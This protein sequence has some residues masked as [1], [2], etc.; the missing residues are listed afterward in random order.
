[1]SIESVL[2]SADTSRVQAG[3]RSWYE[4][5]V[6]FITAGLPGAVVSAAH[7]FYNTGAAVTR[8][9]GSEAQDIDTAKVLT[10]LNENWGKYYQENKNVVDT[11]GFIGGA[12]A[13]GGL[14]LKGLKLLRTGTAA[15]TY[16]TVFGYTAAKEKF[17]LDAALKDISQAGG[18]VYSQ[19]NKNKLL[20]LAYGGADQALQAAVFETAATI[21]MHASP[22]FEDE[23]LKDI[24]WDMGKN[25]IVGGVIG[26]AIQG[27]IQKGIYKQAGKLVESTGRKYNTL[28]GFPESTL[29]LGD[30]LMQFHEAFQALPDSVLSSDT[31]LK[32]VYKIHGQEHPVDLSTEKLYTTGL[33]AT[34]RRALQE[35]KSRITN[36]VSSD[37]SVGSAV[38]SAFEN[39]MAEGRSLKLPAEQIR[40]KLGDYLF[41]LE[42]FEGIGAAPINFDKEI[43]YITPGA[44]IVPGDSPQALFSATRV[45]NKDIGYRIVGNLSDARS[46]VVGTQGV[47][48]VK[49]A[50][51]QGYDIIQHGPK[52]TVVINP[53]SAIFK[54]ARSL[55][56]ENN[57]RTVFNTR[58]MMTSESAIPTI[59]DIATGQKPLTEPTITGV[60]AGNQFFR[61]SPGTFNSAANSVEITAR[62][63]WATKIESLRKI[64]IDP[65]DFS[66]LD[67][68]VQKPEILGDGIFIGNANEATSLEG[69]GMPLREYVLQ[70]KVNTA[71]KLFAEAEVART[72]VDKLRAN[73][74]VPPAELLDKATLHPQEVAYRLNVEQKW[75]Q[76][77]IERDYDVRGLN[78]KD[79]FRPLE[80]YGTRENVVFVYNGATKQKLMQGSFVDAE[81]AF[82]ERKYVAHQK[83]MEASNAV[84]GQHA[85]KWWDIAYDTLKRTADALGA[86]PRGF[87]FSNADYNDPLRAMLQDSGK[88][89]SNVALLRGDEVT[90]RLRPFAQKILDDSRA[91][92]ELSAVTTKAR[93]TTEKLTL[94]ELDGQKRL[95]DLEGLKNYQTEQAR[96][97][98]LG[99]TV[100]P[101]FKVNIELSDPVFNFLLEHQNIH[102]KQLNERKILAAAA[103]QPIHWDP[104]ALYLP[105]IDTRRVPYFAFVRP[106]EGKAFATSE[107]GMLTARTAEELKELASKVGSDYEVIYKADTERYFKAKGDYEFSRALNQPSLDPFMRKQGKLGDFLPS[108]DGKSVLDD[109]ISYHMR[110][111]QQIVRD[112]VEL[113]YA[114]IF[115][116]LKWLSGES[117]KAETSKMQFLG[118]IMAKR[119]EDPFNDYIKLGLN[120]S[121]ESEFTLWHQAN[122]FVDAL[123]SRAYKAV[124]RAFGNAQKN[125]IT[126]EE[127]N[128]E[129][130]RMGLGR[131][132]ESIDA[133]TAAFTGQ[134][135]NLIKSAV[136][137]GNMLLATFG[138]RLDMANAMINVI[139]TPMM[140]AAEVSAIRKLMAT[141]P[142]MMEKFTGLTSVV[143]PANKV[144][145]PTTK[146]MLLEAVRSYFTPEGKALVSGRFK[147]IGVIRTILEQHQQMIE[148]LALVPSVSAGKYSAQVD[149]ALEFGA[150][151]TGNNFAEDFTRYVSGHVMKQM[152]DVAVEAGKMSVK[153]Q[154]AFISIFVNRVQ[155]NYIASQR[156]IAF[157]GTIGAA[158]SLFQTY[159]F[160]LFQ[161]LFRHISNR[162]MRSVMTM[163]GLQ[164]TMFGL[165]GLPMFD[166]INTHLIGSANINE[167]HY[168]AYTFAVQAGGKELGDWLMYGTASAFPIFSEKMPS[169]FSRGDLNPRHVTIIPTTPTQIPI[170]EV[171]SRVVSNLINTAKMIGSGAGV[172]PSLLFGLEHN[173]VNRPLA[174]IAQVLQGASTTSQGSLISSTSDF[175]AI[176]TSARILGARPMDEALALNANYR[177]EAYKAADRARIEDLG[178]TVKTKIRNGSLTEDDVLELQARYAA[179][180]GRIQSFSAAMQ[181]WTTDAQYS[182]LNK[183]ARAQT[184]QYGRYLNEIMGA[185]ELPDALSQGQQQ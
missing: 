170:V 58:T 79:A 41:G 10:D 168:D 68:M 40:Q 59:A 8:V 2:A 122:E 144:A 137:K 133:Y 43:A 114:D 60:S 56:D 54:I 71:R 164:T 171:G 53:N 35:F 176:A 105:P 101:E 151:W 180:G 160:N 26:G 46:V 94:V 88:N 100:T 155:G 28:P 132:F 99:K 142:A 126:W 76:Q 47:V 51:L 106:V 64:T 20:A 158:L 103:G 90:G 93:L 42:G 107:V 19:L 140:L 73:L 145:V 17:Y 174:G 92:A 44:K 129:L 152:T 45:T 139:S 161:Q 77:L 70:Q 75:L 119:I 150:K 112:A 23:S 177:K 37:T 121:K 31:S 49:D 162:D 50:I 11:V 182:V 13:P 124:E 48:S 163:G 159:Q 36:A 5:V 143:D 184:S 9:F 156:P 135:R 69:L 148:D 52:G 117:T 32:F 12:L 91:G 81:A 27:L 57:M 116:E 85:E 113:R 179:M 157:Q 128:N 97:Q 153:E 115:S 80:S 146:K 98:R 131:P 87:A 7:S 83:R 109:Y 25:A 138:L 84:L 141:E 104:E 65:T 185:D 172:L 34:E 134:D 173:G 86:G 123:G 21:T 167:Q 183:V 18:T 118:K 89:V 108:M 147:D 175:S 125:A 149:K 130:D 61:F 24:V 38:A 33:Q 15:G 62:H 55:D 178:V 74:R 22:M 136:A 66:V 96:A 120:I 14:A 16:R 169:L 165:N 1:M 6:D 3:G 82:Q 29:G 4:P 181:R 111:E 102:V 95:V 39:I 72:E 110:K 63:L 78:T 166:A 30:Q 127:A 67:Q 154:N